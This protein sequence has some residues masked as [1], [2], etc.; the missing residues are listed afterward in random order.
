MNHFFWGMCVATFTCAAMFFARFWRQTGDRLFV[1][2]A[3]AF[4][5][6]ALNYLLFALLKVSDD[7]RH[8]FFLLRLT[9]FLCIIA[10]I[11][12]KSRRG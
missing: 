9:A 8:Y 11:I 2:F 12:D 7:S 10:G 3:V 5:L 4:V 6:M 1:T